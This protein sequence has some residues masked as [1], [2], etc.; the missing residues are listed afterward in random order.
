MLV[1]T[2]AM[3]A[4]SVESPFQTVIT[5]A[6]HPLFAKIVLLKSFRI[7][8]GPSRLAIQTYRVQQ[9]W[10]FADNSVVAVRDDPARLQALGD[11]SIGMWL[12]DYDAEPA[13]KER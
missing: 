7:S 8:I 11:T 6:S 12:P 1:E 4:S 13:G 2:S 9:I 10:V 3:G 5:G